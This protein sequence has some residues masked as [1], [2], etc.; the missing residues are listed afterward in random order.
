MGAKEGR[1]EWSRSDDKG[2]F[3]HTSNRWLALGGGSEAKEW[4]RLTKKCEGGFGKD[5]S[6]ANWWRIDQR[7]R[8]LV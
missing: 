3:G 1:K 7:K 2:A 8:D 4:V 6:P 5:A